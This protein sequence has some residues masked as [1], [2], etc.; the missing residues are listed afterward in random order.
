MI[1]MAVVFLGLKRKQKS[2]PGLWLFL[3]KKKK[4]IPTRICEGTCVFLL[5]VVFG[6]LKKKKSLPGLVK[7]QIV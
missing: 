3:P 5:A 4:K 7:G 2:I 6:G 1:L